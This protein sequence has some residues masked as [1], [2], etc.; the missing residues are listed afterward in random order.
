MASYHTGT[1]RGPQNFVDTG[2][3]LCGWGSAHPLE[4]RSSL[5]SHPHVLPAHPLETRSSLVSHPHV[6]PYSPARN[7]LLPSLSP[8]CVTIP[9]LLILRQTVW[10]YIWRTAGNRKQIVSAFMVNPVGISPHLVWSPCKIWLLLFILSHKTLGRLPT[11]LGWGMAELLETHFCHTRYHTKFGH[12]R[13]NRMGVSSGPKNFGML[14][15]TP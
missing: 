7:T 1:S 3:H 2:Y 11:L 14:G 12:P 5:V 15:P 6:L 8:P 9:N 13:S 4:T 10:V